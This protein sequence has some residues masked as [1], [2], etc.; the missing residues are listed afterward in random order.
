MVR[1]RLGPGIAVCLVALA[2]AGCG[3]PHACGDDG[4][5]CVPEAGVSLLAPGWQEHGVPASGST[6]FEIAPEETWPGGI[7]LSDGSEI[8]DPPPTDLAEVELAVRKSRDA[9][10]PSAIFFVRQFLEAETEGV[11]LPIG[12]AVRVRYLKLF[13]GPGAR[14]A[15]DYWFYVDDRLLVLTWVGAAWTD[16]VP[17]SSPPYFEEMAESIRLIE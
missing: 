5:I 10:P 13:F 12:P 17:A 16:Q 1:R 15:I 3:G 6:L 8:F 7:K 14:P 9:R 2:L 11:E 4:R